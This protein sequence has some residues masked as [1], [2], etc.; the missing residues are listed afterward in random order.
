VTQEP[1]CFLS[2]ACYGEAFYGLA[3]QGVGVLILLGVFFLP[4]VA[5]VSQQNF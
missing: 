4:T 1:S 5:P 3:V 2:V